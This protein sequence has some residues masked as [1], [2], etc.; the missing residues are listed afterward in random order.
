MAGSPP[1]LCVPIDMR[2]QGG[3]YTFLGYLAAWLSRNGLGFTH[4]ID[5]EYDILF[6]NSWVVPPAVVRRQKR[7][8]PALRVVHRIDGSAVDYGRPP[9]AD[10]IQ[11]RVNLFADLTIFQ[12]RYSRHSTR[13]KFRV[14]VHDGP[15]IYNPVDV[16]CFAPAGPRLDLPANGPRVACA[17]W[18]VNP[19][20]GAADI[21]A[22]A[23]AHRSVTFVLCGRFDAVATRPNVVRLGHL[24][25]EAM[26]RALRSCDVFLNLSE[27]ESCPNVVLE[28][29]ASGLPVLFRDSG[30][31]PELVADCGCAVDR[32]T[33][34]AM[35]QDVLSRREALGQA[36]RLRAVRH[37]AADRVFPQYWAA[38]EASRRLPLPSLAETV[39]LAVAGFPVLPPVRTPAQAVASIGR[40]TIRMLRAGGGPR[41]GSRRRIGWVTYDSFPN[42]KRRLAN[43]DSFTGM[44]TGNV[45]R[46]LNG[47]AGDLWNELYDPEVRYDVVVFQK[48][49]DARA[50]AEVD[51]IRSAGGRV[52]FDANVN[53]YE[54][55]GDYFIPGT[56][57]T[58]EQRRDAERMTAIADL[59]VADSSYL[60]SVIQPLNPRVVWIPDNVDPTVYRG[61][62]RHAAGGPLRL[63]WS[64]IAKKAGHLLEIRDALAQLRDVELTLVADERPAVMDDLE[65]CLPCRFEPYSNRRYARIL[66]TSDVIISPKRLV[67]AYEM[68]HTEYKITLGMAVGLP[69]VAQ[70]QQSY[71]EAIEYRGGGVLCDTIADWVSALH[72]LRDP[73][74]RSD[75]GVRAAATVAER[76]STP[77]VAERYGEA[78]RQVL[79]TDAAG[80][81]AAS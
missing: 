6:A 80:S 8:R 25:R 46:W 40:R 72:R 44:R 78:L 49:M 33:F 67:N 7:R 61:H 81:V 73:A 68:A 15:L 50:Q 31:V 77:R 45:A 63:V 54:L 43:L 66:R 4:D 51:K 62:R 30:G 55:W 32:S 56:R 69:A 64:G 14:I 27:N 35:L 74:V 52:I 58:D 2:P 22:L 48:V 5:G 41:G 26:A 24:G 39:R 79:A 76:Y 71:R 53:Y 23:E 11:A 65:Q 28:A 34:A 13:E 59:V 37:F 47:H 18:S 75:L 21:D 42:R 16:E 17:S 19:R 38:F 1:R 29:L 60:R 12:S 3:M 10:R 36:A 70:P 9:A 20:K 57:P